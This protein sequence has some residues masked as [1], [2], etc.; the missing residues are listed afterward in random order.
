[1][2][3]SLLDT[4]DNLALVQVQPVSTG[5]SARALHHPYSWTRR[6]KSSEFPSVVLLSEEPSVVTATRVVL[7]FPNV[8]KTWAMYCNVDGPKA[9]NDNKALPTKFIQLCY[10]SAVR[11]I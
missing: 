8:H 6:N 4:Q 1:M 9:P 5:L 2:H 3:A 11:V 7:R 10:Y